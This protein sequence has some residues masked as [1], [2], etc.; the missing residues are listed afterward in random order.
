MEVHDEI[1]HVGVIHRLL[2][3]R[4]PGRV[5]RRIIRIK[6]D[7]LDLVEILECRVR[8]VGEFAPDHEMEQLLG[9]AV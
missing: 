9:R 5:G 8:E 3:F 7:D 4:P 1:A 2:R 6:T